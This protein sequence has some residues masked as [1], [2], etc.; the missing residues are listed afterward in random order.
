MFGFHSLSAPATLF[1]G[2]VSSLTS[3]PSAPTGACPEIAA[4]RHS[5]V[6]A[7]SLPG[8]TALLVVAAQWAQLLRSKQGKRELGCVFVGGEQSLVLV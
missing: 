5:F 2:L 8:K 1:A 6:C 4:G 3:F 7:C